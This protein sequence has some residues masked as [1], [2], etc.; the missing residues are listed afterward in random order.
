MIN[1]LNNILLKKIIINKEFHNIHKGESCYL[2]GNG[3]S[4]KNMDLKKFNDRISIGCNSLFLHKNFSDL[5]CRYYQIL[6]PLFFLPYYKF[7]G[8]FQRNYLSGLYKEQIIINKSVYFFTS[9]YN[10][11][12]VYSKNIRYEHHFGKIYPE[13][14]DND[15]DN[16]FSFMSGTL[17]SLIGMAIYMGFEKATLVGMD[18]TFNTSM[19]HHFFEKGKGVINNNKTYKEDFFN[20]IMNKIE[21]E[22]ITLENSKGDVL[23]HKKYS[24]FTGKKERY[25]ENTECVNR[26][27][28]NELD[29]MGFYKI[30]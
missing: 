13:F 20:K 7:Y 10:I 24:D 25:L 28:L 14:E 21:L 4:L 9:I 29:K 6:P 12:S 8:K 23:K 3:V 18:Y 17:D 26:E 15:L 1:I 2:F 27:H 19:S 5:D 16:T 30:Y 11:F 22:T